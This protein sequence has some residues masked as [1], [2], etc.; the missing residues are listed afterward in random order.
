[1]TKQNLKFIE[2]LG[3]AA[4]GLWLCGCANGNNGS[5]A[6]DSMMSSTEKV[7]G[8]PV[9]T[10]LKSK[11]GSSRLASQPK[12]TTPLPPSELRFDFAANM[13]LAHLR[14]GGLLLDFGTTSRNKYT[15]GDWKTGWR[16]NYT[17]DGTTLSY[18]EDKAARVFFFLGEAEAGNGRLIIRA[19]GIGKKATGRLYLNGEGLGPVVF[20]SRF[21]HVAVDT[22]GKLK[23]GNNELLLRVNPAE[24][25]ADGKL[26]RLAVDYIRVIPEGASEVQAAASVSSV[27]S[28]SN[29][30][31]DSALRLTAGDRL[32]WYLPVPKMAFV[33]IKLRAV[34]ESKSGVV[35][36]SVSQ[37]GLPSKELLR[38]TV[39]QKGDIASV[40]L[41][42]CDDDVCAVDV[43]VHK[44]EV[45]FEKLQMRLPSLPKNEASGKRAATNVV[46]ILIDTLRADHLSSY[47][48]ET[49]VQTP[50][51]D[52][53]AKESMVFENAWAQENWTKP[54]ITSLLS[55]LY[56]ATHQN[57]TEQNKV[58]SSVVMIQEHLQKLG[59][60]TAGFVANGYISDKFGFKRGW[61]TWTN[62]VREGKRNRAQFVAE[63]AVAWLK[64]RNESKPF[65]LYVH[66]IDP[67]VPYIPP[68]KY[69]ALY[70]NE[71][72]NGIVEA[73]K[74]ADLLGKVKIG[75]ARLNDRDKF[76]LEA[77]YDG[78][79]SYHD[80]HIVKV[81]DELK[82]QGLL[83]NTV[84]VVTADHGEEFFEHGSVGHG[85]SLYEELLHVPLFVRL[86]GA[87]PESGARFTEMVELVDVAPTVCEMTGVTVP[88]GVEGK[89][90]APQ[91]NGS[92]IDW[93][94]VAFS[95]FMEGQLTVRTIRY[96][97]IYR[98][99]STTVFDLE[100]D[101]LETA[102][103]TAERPEAFVLLRD[104][105][106]VH[107]GGF[108]PTGELNAG[109]S[110]T[111][112]KSGTSP[113]NKPPKVH[114]RENA[115]I[116][117]ETRKQLKA[118][119]YM[120]D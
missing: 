10:S 29:G 47:N 26:A 74:T 37:R 36:L 16:G 31:V 21:S 80:D 84:L 113:A 32:T 35:T 13:D 79:I 66:T 109:S 99:L 42:E 112:G 2:R 100:T 73:T 50:F 82:E 28:S 70:D 71:P 12:D 108:A 93:P 55:G 6:T 107:M 46:L 101:P 7:A 116:D 91:L 61:D 87:K 56:S 95:E 72:Y 110:R 39:D 94:N 11:S 120:G 45:F 77:L 104:M 30:G 41:Q 65:F 97:L 106:G 89:S 27:L 75:A 88:E 78:E 52:A 17:L 90:L 25:A 98:G 102:D 118:L 63:E 38:Q 3:Y 15:V 62:Y 40:P 54:S 22:Q 68:A 48:R 9:V 103:L 119:G 59:F 49:R 34:G 76:R 114:Q 85:H 69:R 115:N 60:E 81:Y 111:S 53:L 19:R 105:L 24:R 51:L 20:E 14:S 57:K 18:I 44:G 67:H 5:H 58:P 33:T 86:P 64:K 43:E 8:M 1:M 4:I 117:A 92:E 23:A 83:E 96:K